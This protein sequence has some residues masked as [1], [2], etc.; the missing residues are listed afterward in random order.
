MFS[1]FI[2]KW[3]QRRLAK[4]LRKPQGQAGERTGQMMNKANETLYDF[5][6]RSM[7]WNGQLHL[8]EIG[9][10]NGKF[11]EKLFA[12]APGIQ[13]AGLDYSDD[14]VKAAHIY[15]REF[16][17]SGRLSLHQGSSDR[18]PFPDNHFDIIFCINVIYFW[19]N[20]S[21]HLQ[22]IKRVLKPGGSF[23][24]TIRSKESMAQLPFTKYNFIT[25]SED[26]WD[27]IT[28]ENG[29]HLRHTYQLEEPGMVF[30]EETLELRSSCLWAVKE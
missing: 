9:F 2:E 26:E 29:L 30:R 24:A 11:F 4:Q 19:N 12:A 14:M 8:L 20:T 22:E 21:A 18:M 25:W 1:N 17:E 13:V 28:A 6:L 27:K 3:K 15:N 16:I 5:T 23:Y 7:Q 10:G